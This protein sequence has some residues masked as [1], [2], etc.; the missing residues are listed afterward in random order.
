MKKLDKL[1]HVVGNC[2]R[3]LIV[4]LLLGGIA[5]LALPGLR[6]QLIGALPFLILL[7][8]PLMHIFMHRRHNHHRDGDNTQTGGGG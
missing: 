2:G 6:E 7:L 4:V 5:Y 1:T 3:G 8:C